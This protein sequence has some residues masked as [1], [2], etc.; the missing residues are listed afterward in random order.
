VTWLKGRP[1]WQLLCGLIVALIALKA[2]LTSA[3]G[4][5]LHYD[6]AQYWEWSQ[7]LDWSYYSKGPLVAWLIALAEHL[8][9]HGEWQVRLFAWLCHGIFLALLFVLTRLLWKNR[10]AAWWA[11]IITLTT[12]LYFT[13]GL[14]M[15]TDVF[16]L[17]FWTWGL[18]AAQRAIYQE[19][20]HAWY[21]L[22]AAVGLGALT[23]LSIGLLPAIVGMLVLI[24]PQ[25]RRYLATPHVWGGMVLILVCMSPLLLWNY[26]N[27]WVMFRHE[28]GHVGYDEWSFTRLIEYILGQW[29]ALSPLMVIVAITVVAHFPQ[30]I[31]HRLFW[32]ISLVCTVFFFLKAGSAKV[33]L[34]WPA[35]AY[36]GFII[37]FAG[38]IP[39]FTTFKRRLVIIAM[40]M[41][42]TFMAVGYFPYFFG[43]PAKLEP[44]KVV[45]SWQQS[46]TT[47]S[48]MAPETDFILTDKYELAGELAFYWPHRIPVY[49]TGSATR[50]FNQHD[51]WPAIDREAGR[52]AIYIST[53]PE[54]PAELARAFNR[55]VELQP[56]IA[57]TYDA[58]ILRTLYV[59]HCS[60]YVSIIWP[61]PELY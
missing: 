30:V 55:C 47:I 60:H 52:D 21:E 3:A 43:L 58:S 7:F 57:F 19:Q 4:F 59:R 56:A 41:S 36:I 37:L 22:G 61:K 26:H 40:V 54:P 9:G 48:S 17:T 50:R 42:V 33:Q 51:L 1:D 14:V 25:W 35:P 2:W 32:L 53:H 18:W 10:A 23:K 29:L 27:D 31:R 12:P 20:A 45:K 49:I 15:T 11:T 44:F 34:N 6:E 8:F 38:A 24:I 39:A 13:L 5:E 46:I 16:L 28:L